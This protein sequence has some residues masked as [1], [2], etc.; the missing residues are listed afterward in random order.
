MLRAAMNNAYVIWTN[1]YAWNSAAAIFIKQKLQDIFLKLYR[2]TP[3]IRYLPEHFS[4][5]DK[6]NGK[7]MDID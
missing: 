7:E 4:V 3:T 6:H 2:T 1:I 5:S